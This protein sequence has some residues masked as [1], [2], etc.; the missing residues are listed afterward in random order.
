MKSF[1]ILLSRP[2]LTFSHC[3]NFT[4][5]YLVASTLLLILALGSGEV[6]AAPV[7]AFGACIDA[8]PSGGGT[9]GG[10]PSGGGGGG[11]GEA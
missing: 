4:T 7:C 8:T 3:I 2:P 6:Q 1:D 11:A 9:G 10:G 5:S